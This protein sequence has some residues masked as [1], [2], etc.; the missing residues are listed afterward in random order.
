[1]LRSRSRFINRNNEIMGLTMSEKPRAKGE[2]LE[3]RN[4]SATKLELG[5][6]GRRA[7]GSNGKASWNGKTIASRK[8]SCEIQSDL[9]DFSP[10]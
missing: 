8:T 7:Q 4:S 1:M 6:S 5:K 10:T 3:G 2:P 9:S